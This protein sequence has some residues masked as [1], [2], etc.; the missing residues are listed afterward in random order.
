MHS[1][2]DVVMTY[3]EMDEMVGEML[4]KKGFIGPG[5]SVKV[6]VLTIDRVMGEGYNLRV[7]VTPLEASESLD[8]PILRG[9][10]MPC[11]QNGS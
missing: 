10:S 1:T 7:S 11:A 2:N 8:T 6:S 5:R 3:D 4:K 9:V